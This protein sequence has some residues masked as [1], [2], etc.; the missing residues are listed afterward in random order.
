MS[1][2]DT[3]TTEGQVVRILD[4]L[5]KIRKETGLTLITWIRLCMVHVMTQELV[6]NMGRPVL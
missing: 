2:S 3:R 4:Q 1:E 5:L 6:W